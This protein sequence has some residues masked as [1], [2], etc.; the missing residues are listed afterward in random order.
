VA[1]GEQGA[2]CG[3]D[4]VEPGTGFAAPLVPGEEEPVGVVGGLFVAFEVG[5]GAGQSAEPSGAR[6]VGGGVLQRLARGGQVVRTSS[7]EVGVGL[8]VA[9]ERGVFGLPGGGVLGRGFAG[10][11]GGS[12]VVAE[13]EVGRR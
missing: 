1:A 8:D 7:V 4:S 10:L 12:R 11:L 6:A 2:P 5:D 13:P 9:P 3:K